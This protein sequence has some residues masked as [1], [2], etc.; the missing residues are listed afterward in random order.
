LADPARVDEAVA[1]SQVAMGY[2]LRV[3]QEDHAL[4]DV[5]DE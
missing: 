2:Y 1:G 5:G 3:V 4:Q